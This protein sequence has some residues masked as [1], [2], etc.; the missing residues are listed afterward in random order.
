MA[1]AEHEF[2]LLLEAGPGITR[3]AALEQAA[4]SGAAEAEEQLRN[5][6]ALPEGAAHVLAWFGELSNARRC[7]LAGMEAI[8]FAD[9]EAW[10]RLTGARPTAREVR[11]IRGLDDL[12]RRTLTPKAKD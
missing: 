4:R 2:S 12:F 9:V 1:H 3:R 11:L 6:T 5:P 10:S 8:G 7:G